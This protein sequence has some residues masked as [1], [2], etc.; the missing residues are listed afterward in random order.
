DL[1]PPT[2]DVAKDLKDVAPDA[3]KKVDDA[4]MKQEGAKNDL[5]KNDPMAGAEKAN[6]AAKK[7]DEAAKDVTD[8]LAEKRG[9][10]ANDQAALMPNNVDPNAAAM[11]LAKAIEQ[12]NKAQDKADEAAKALD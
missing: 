3:A 9:I 1:Q 8:K 5:A 4:G 6:D 11:Q 12:A 2:K 10:E 7:L